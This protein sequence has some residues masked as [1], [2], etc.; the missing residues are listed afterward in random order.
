M[1]YYLT[2]DCCGKEFRTYPCYD[3]RMRKHRFCSKACEA[4]F[5]SLKNTR[6]SWSGG[7]L[8]R[9]TGYIYVKI[10]GKNVPEHKLVME[11]LIGRQLLPDEVV[12]H[13]NGVKTDN[14]PENLRLMKNGEHSALHAEQNRMLNIG[15]KCLCCLKVK[16]IH[17][18]G[19]C[20]RCYHKSAANG[21][22][23]RWKTKQ[24]IR[25]S[26]LEAV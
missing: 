2:C 8:N 10:D 16:K 26:D 15:R 17:A 24:Q 12:H 9:T 25:C 6:E 11:R 7:W 18:R 23:E 4:D 20:E 13:I 21:S 3:K 14:R 1:A 5:N 22:L 19:L